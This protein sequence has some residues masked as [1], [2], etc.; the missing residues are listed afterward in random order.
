MRYVAVADEALK[1][2]IR[3][4]PKPVLAARIKEAREA[5]GYTHD[6]LGELCGGMYRQ[7]LISYEKAKYQPS[8]SALRR[9]AEHTK[10]PVDWFLNGSGDAPFQ[11]DGPGDA[12]RA[13]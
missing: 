7:T 12:G 3:Q 9:I 13:A 5:M 11:T 6:H 4:T 10:K 1:D 8:P 2:R